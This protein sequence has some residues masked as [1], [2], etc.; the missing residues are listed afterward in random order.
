MKNYQKLITGIVLTCLFSCAG[1]KKNT[2][3][4]VENQ[5]EVVEVEKKWET[6]NIGAVG[7]TMSEM[8]YDIESI[9]VKEGSWVRINLENKG[10]D[11]SMMH[12]IVFINYGT[13]KEV[14]SEA[15]KIWP[16]QNFVSNKK[17]IIAY[18]AVAKPGESVVLEF[19]APKKGNYEY[20]CTYPGHAEIMRGY[21]FVK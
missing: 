10:I 7:N 4:S 20:L 3:K 19:K 17:N 16:S 13:R 21:F 15:I 14:A 1:E 12:N 9:T 8:K 18:S 11:N 6:F 5:I 2:E